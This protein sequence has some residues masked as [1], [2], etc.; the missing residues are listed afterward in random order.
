M[1]RRLLPG[2]LACVIVFVS[3][4]YRFLSMDLTDDDYL[5][6]A[7]GRQIQHFGEWPLRDLAEC[8]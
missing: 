4:G 6:F 7:I 2:V 3:F 5:F 1:A 8:Q